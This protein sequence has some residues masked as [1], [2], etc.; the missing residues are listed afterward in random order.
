MPSQYPFLMPYQEHYVGPKLT[1]VQWEDEKTYCFQ[2]EC[3]GVTVARRKDSNF[4]NGTKLLNV[5]GMTRG[6][7]DGILKN[8]Q[9]RYVVKS[10]SMMLKG[11]WIPLQRA[12]DL[13]R[14]HGVL[15]MLYPLFEPNI[16]SFY[17]S[18]IVS[19]GSH[20]ID[21]ELS[22]RWNQHSLAASRPYRSFPPALT[23]P[24]ISVDMG[25]VDM[26]HQ[27][28]CYDS[29]PTDRHFPQDLSYPAPKPECRQ[30]SDLAHSPFFATTPV[31]YSFPSQPPTTPVSPTSCPNP[32]EEIN[33]SY[34]FL[35][36]HPDPQ[37]IKRPVS[38]LVYHA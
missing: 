24:P 36:Y 23:L 21:I 38:S 33:S 34:Q 13:A 25:Y 26:D 16:E 15:E 19:L 5:V 6:K 8:E 35:N 1:A 4:I 30:A 11:V 29:T 18:P 27:A 31:T 20:P 37:Q 32:T 2:V 17:Y 7:R 28:F 10:G 12:S 22:S 9:G 3:R 14:E